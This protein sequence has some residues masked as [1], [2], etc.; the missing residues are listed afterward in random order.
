VDQEEAATICICP[1]C[2]TFV[3]CDESVAFCVYAEGKSACI[4]EEKGCICGG[5]PVHDMENF[6]YGYYCTQGSEVAQANE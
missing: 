1:E 6:L 3:A 2:P 5:C 4:T